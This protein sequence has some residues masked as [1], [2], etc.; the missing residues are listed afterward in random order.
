[1]SDAGLKIVFEKD[2]YMMV[3]G[4][5]ILLRGV[6]FGTLYKLLG[7]TIS[8]GLN[9]SIIRE[10]GFEIGKKSYSL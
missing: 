1:M 6:W 8:D 9:S 4:E 3:Q 2:T 10:S 7:S 5:T